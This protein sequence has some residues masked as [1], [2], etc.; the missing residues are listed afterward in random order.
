MIFI[1]V[2]LLIGGNDIEPTDLHTATANVEMTILSKWSY[3]D[4]TN[5]TNT[6]TK[7]NSTLSDNIINAF[8]SATALKNTNETKDMFNVSYKSIEP[9]FGNHLK[10]HTK[11][12]ISADISSER[13][14]DKMLSS[15]VI[16][17]D[18]TKKLSVNTH[19]NICLTLNLH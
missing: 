6:N 4:F 13:A 10:H 2:L 9:V 12:K 3:L 11:V 16:E 7:N 14:M 15:M 5:T 19:L 18:A 1:L 8:I 17:K